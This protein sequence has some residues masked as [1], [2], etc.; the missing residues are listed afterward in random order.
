MCKYYTTF[1]SE[2]QDLISPVSVTETVGE[3]GERK[4]EE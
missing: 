2:F 4:A 1:S 3:M